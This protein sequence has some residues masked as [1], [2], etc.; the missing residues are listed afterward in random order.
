MFVFKAFTTGDEASGEGVFAADFAEDLEDLGGEF[1]SRGDDEGA[2]TIEGGPFF[3]VE[4]FED[5]DEEGEG[6]A[7]AG[8]RGAED[9]AAFECWGE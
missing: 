4:G 5:G 1:A 7:A 6:F 8:L 9:V 3:A 2:E